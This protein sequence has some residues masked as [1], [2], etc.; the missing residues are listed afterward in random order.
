MANRLLLPHFAWVSPSHV[1][2]VEARMRDSVVIPP[3][4]KFTGI[5]IVTDR[6]QYPLGAPGTLDVGWPRE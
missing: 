6:S 3:S 1:C 5:E 4:F 2:S